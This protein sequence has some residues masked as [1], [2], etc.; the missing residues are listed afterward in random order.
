MSRELKTLKKEERRRQAAYWRMDPKEKERE[1]AMRAFE[2]RRE[3]AVMNCTHEAM[4]AFEILR[5][6][7]VQCME[8]NLI[9]SEEATR[10]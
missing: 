4:R 7:V 2:V 3:W 1:E 9:I 5:A 10:V 6:R 8:C